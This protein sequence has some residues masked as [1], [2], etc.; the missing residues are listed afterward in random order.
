MQFLPTKDFVRRFANRINSD[1]G[2]SVTLS[3]VYEAVS[4]AFNYRNW[5]TFSA[6]LQA[7]DEK[8]AFSIEGSGLELGSRIQV[9]DSFT[10]IA[11]TTSPNSNF[12]QVPEMAA[13]RVTQQELDRLME[14]RDMV[15]VTD[16]KYI[17]A[18]VEALATG[19]FP[20]KNSS[21]H[22]FNPKETSITVHGGG[23]MFHCYLKGSGHKVQSCFIR[24]DVLKRAM[25]HRDAG[26]G[27]NGM[28]WM[29]NNLLLAL[30]ESDY[31][32]GID[33]ICLITEAINP[34]GLPVEEVDFGSDQLRLRQEV[35]HWC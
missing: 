8:I 23:F 14:L 18:R 16:S 2:A 19:F 13:L 33:Q 15:L 6:A 31:D 22:Y 20:T 34:E 12:E 30:L 7:N 17:C 3:K 26:K 1:L 32:A 24:F 4:R 11:E 5:D 28:C 25:N 10:L 21:G 9:D 35:G 29:T 27:A